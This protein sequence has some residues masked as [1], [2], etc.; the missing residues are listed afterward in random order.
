[1]LRH[2]FFIILLALFV[3]LTP[4]LRP[5]LAQDEVVHFVLNKNYYYVNDQ[6]QAM[7]AVTFIEN[8]RTYV[9]IRFLGESLG[10]KV[11]WNGQLQ[12]V[13]LTKDDIVVHL[14]VGQKKILVL[15]KSAGL[16]NNIAGFISKA[17]NMDVAPLTT[18]GRTY[19]PARFVAEALGYKVHWDASINTVTVSKTGVFNPPPVP[20][21]PFNPPIYYIRHD[22]VIDAD[23]A[24]RLYGPLVP[25]TELVGNGYTVALKLN[26][27][28]VV[29]NPDAQVGSDYREK[30]VPGTG[31]LLKNYLSVPFKTRDSKSYSGGNLIDSHANFYPLKEM[32]LLG[33][34][35]EQN[36]FWNPDTQTMVIYGSYHDYDKYTV[37]KV[38][39]GQ[40]PYSL[41]LSPL[42][43]MEKGSLLVHNGHYHWIA[44]QAFGRGTIPTFSRQL[45]D[46]EA[47][48]VALYTPRHPS[49]S[50]Y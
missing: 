35:P 33:G 39:A 45:F 21:D 8:S 31:T 13:T 38:T 16:V 26:S 7:D 5:A 11:D 3:I 32:L 25:P 46:D 40:R 14:V 18:N 24:Q 4:G 41:S 23:V 15:D 34:F 29:I 2:Y 30:L 43:L 9:P 44:G 6:K 12:M 20:G 28:D 27:R 36:I 17:S 48:F 50:P 1:M 22:P 47:P 19:L 37:I 10:A 49:R 42:P